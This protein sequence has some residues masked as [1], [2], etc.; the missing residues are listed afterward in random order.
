MIDFEKESQMSEAE[1]GR[2]VRWLSRQNTAVLIEV[3]KAEKKQF[4][5]LKNLAISNEMDEVSTLAFL[6]AVK[7]IYKKIADK[8]SKNKTG[9]LN[10]IKSPIKLRVKQLGRPK[11]REKYEKMLNL[12]STIFSLRDEEELSYNKISKYL[13]KWHKLEVSHTYVRK[14]YID[15]NKEK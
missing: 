2:L 7:Q 3:K 6:V 1:R 10:D 9:D 8:R 4:F 11:K 5:R 13:L 15:L 14:F 12:I